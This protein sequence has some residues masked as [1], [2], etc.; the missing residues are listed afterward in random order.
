MASGPNFTLY[1]FHAVWL[2]VWDD[3]EKMSHRQRMRAGDHYFPE[4]FQIDGES[5]VQDTVTCTVV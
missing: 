4:A 2:H 3:H 5:L 1:R